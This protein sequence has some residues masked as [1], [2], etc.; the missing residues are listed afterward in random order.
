M[1]ADEVFREIC[2][3]VGWLMRRPPQS[4]FPLQRARTIRIHRQTIATG[5][6]RFAL[7][8]LVKSGHIT[9][10]RSSIGE[11]LSLTNKGIIKA[12]AACIA[13]NSQPLPEGQIT[14]AIFDVPES[15]RTKRKMLRLLLKRLGFRQIQQSAWS[16]RR[17]TVL[18]LRHY[19]RLVGI[20]KWLRVFIA[21]DDGRD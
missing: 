9:I 4:P 1:A 20:D 2:S 7:R 18:H 5:S 13:D 8:S 12:I 21:F 19:A 14:I 16:T 10:K 3:R 11:V 6:S 15:Q 17:D